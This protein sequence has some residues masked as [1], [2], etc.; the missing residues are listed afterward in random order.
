MHHTQRRTYLKN[1]LATALAAGPIGHAIAQTQTAAALEAKAPPLPKLGSAL[2]VPRIT[3]LDGTVFDPAK[4]EGQPLLVYWWAS[5]CPFC[6]LQSP[7]M[8]KLWR[9][10]KS[11]GLQMLALSIDVKPEPAM[12]YLKAKG[13]SF[14]AAWASPEWRNAFP[15]PQGLPVTLLRGRDGKLQL[16]EKGQLFAEDVDAIADMI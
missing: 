11:R 16:A 6:A 1:A 12:A 4:A 2:K 5:T 3:L 10:Q 15:K 8:D 9:S 14:P 13:Y 7:S